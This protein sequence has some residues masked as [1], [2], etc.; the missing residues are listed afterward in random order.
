MD[1]ALLVTA[2]LI[3]PL[4]GDAPRLDGL[5]EAL[6]SR[7]GGGR[8]GYRVDR[9]YP[10]PPQGVIPIPLGRSWLGPWLV[11][12]CSD[13]IT[14]EPVAD[15]HEH[16]SRRIGAE[17]A[18]LL[19][20]GNRSVVNTTNT[21]TKSYRL[22]IRVRRVARVRWFA[23]GDTAATLGLLRRCSAIGKKTSVGY[24]RVAWWEVERTGLPCWWY[25]PP[26]TTGLAGPLL[27]A[28][29][30]RGGW[31]PTGL[32]GWRED[33]ASVCPP[34]WHPERYCECVVPC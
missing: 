6:I 23:E 29:L 7:P 2:R 24:G 26:E 13:P 32:E 17:D 9:N 18:G 11:G 30:P 22:P 12:H 4:A 14:P 33:F 20:P 8:P 25:A 34:A 16:V 3:S 28:T 31:L 10:A 15:H 1:D 21:W 27:M 19:A 5:M